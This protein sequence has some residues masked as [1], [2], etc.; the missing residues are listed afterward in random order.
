M[1]I[2]LTTGV[3]HL[4]F[5]ERPQ[6]GSPYPEGLAVAHRAITGD[7]SGNPLT[8]SILADAGFLY[9]LELLQV[10]RGAA[11]II[12]T[13]LIT[14]HRWAS[15]RS[16]LGDSAFD[17]NWQM[18]GLAATTFATYT[19]IT[20]SAARGP[21]PLTEIRRFPMGRTDN[22]PLQQL[23]LITFDINVDTIT[24]EFAVV[25]TYWRKEAL[26][27]PGFL[28]SFFEAPVIPTPLKQGA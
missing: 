8:L 15:D 11:A 4:P 6:Y 2:A 14:S 21:S 10:A 26:A 17:L 7:A 28:S 1:A 23:M 13:H 19:L 25:L 24:H 20:G 16:G 22:V 27:L 9:R 18:V 3:V 5:G 12:Q